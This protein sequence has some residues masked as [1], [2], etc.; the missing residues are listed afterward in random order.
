MLKE[1]LEC[2]RRRYDDGTDPTWFGE[3][4]LV[5]YSAGEG[6][7]SSRLA[8]WSGAGSIQPML[9]RRR[10]VADSESWMLE[11]LGSN[12]LRPRWPPA[13]GVFGHRTKDE[14]KD[15]C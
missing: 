3:Y 11:T 10:T 2:V 12:R 13:G 9:L 7:E 4:P 15:G 5:V 8:L 1:D 6:P 14:L